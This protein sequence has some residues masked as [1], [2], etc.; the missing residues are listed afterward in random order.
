MET[1]WKVTGNP[2]Q[3]TSCLTGRWLETRN[4]PYPQTKNR[5]LEESRASPYVV[6]FSGP[7]FGDVDP[8]ESDCVIWQQK[9]MSRNWRPWDTDLDH[10]TVE[11]S[12]FFC[13]T[14]FTLCPSVFVN[15]KRQKHH[16]FSMANCGFSWLYSKGTV[17][18]CSTNPICGRCRRA[19]ACQRLLRQLSDALKYST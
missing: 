8:P 7:F 18:S 19:I 14:Y 5:N 1:D 15:K 4:R 17:W 2:Q 16:G 12:H 11:T 10:F 3:T 6:C 9:G 13:T